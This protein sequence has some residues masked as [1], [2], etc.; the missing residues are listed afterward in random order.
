MFSRYVPILNCCMV[1][2]SV[3]IYSALAFASNTPAAWQTDGNLKYRLVNSA[4]PSSSIY[5]SLIG[6]NAIDHTLGARLNFE[7]DRNQWSADISYQAAVVQGDGARLA[8][9][10]SDEFS[11]IDPTLS[12]S[13][14]AVSDDAGRLLDLS[15]LISQSNSHGVGH[16]L[17]RLN[18]GYQSEKNIFRIGRQAL[19]WGNGLIYTP[20]DFINPFDPTAIDREYKTGDDMVYA[21]HLFS[22]GDDLQTAWVV[23]RDKAGDISQKVNSL[24]VKYHG[25]FKAS[26]FDFLIASHYGD[27]VIGLGGRV[28]V[29]GS[30]VRGDWLVSNTDH[31]TFD[32]LVAN[33]SYSWVSWEKNITGSLEYFHSGVGSHLHNGRLDE[34]LR[35]PE[36]VDRITRGELFTLGRDYLAGSA[37]VE[38]APLWLLSTNIF[39]NMSDNSALAQIVSNHDVGQNGQFVMAATLPMGP[40]GS[41]FGGLVVNTANDQLMQ[42]FN[43]SSWSLYAQIAWY[44]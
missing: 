2:C 41:E 13:A 29:G 10:S 31:G 20:M 35:N 3:V 9:L 17:D 38:M 27:R 8:T 4:F 22:N 42:N 21:Q 34:L 16:R 5:Q 43:E 11:F 39:Y 23:R 33:I 37:A 18:V 12:L 7:I 1:V 19:S 25:F 6:D 15:E 24:A 30:I 44:F 28:S 40:K 32:S 14:S 26:E 36:L